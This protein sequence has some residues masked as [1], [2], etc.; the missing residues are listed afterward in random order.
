M[1]I[2]QGDPWEGTAHLLVSI[3]LETRLG[4]EAQGA[5]FEDSV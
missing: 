4:K 1:R 3:Y 5:V 2:S